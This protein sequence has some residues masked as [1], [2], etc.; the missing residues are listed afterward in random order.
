MAHVELAAPDLP[1]R[2][3][4]VPF[5][6]GAAGVRPWLVLVVGLPG[7]VE[8]LDGGR[9]RLTGAELFAQH[10]LTLAAPLGP[11]PRRRRPAV[12]PGRLAT[13]ADDGAG[14]HRRARPRLA[15]H[16]RGRRLDS[17][18]RLVAV[19][20]RFG[21]P[22]AASTPGRSAPSPIR[23]T[24]PRSPSASTR[25]PRRRRRELRAR[26]FGRAAVGVEPF[27][28]EPLA[29]GG[30]LTVVPQPGDPPLFDDLPG[31]RRRGRRVARRQR[32][33]GRPVGAD[34]AALRRA[35]ASRPRRRRAVAVATAGR[36]R[37]A[38][39]LAARAARRSS[40]PWCRRPRRLGGDRVAG[41]DQRR[42]HT[43]GRR[44]GRRRATHPSPGA[45]VSVRR[46]ACGCG[47]CRPSRW[48]DWR[49]CRR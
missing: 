47:G 34:D 26:R 5:A 33:A 38:R 44:G 27:A 35:V 41:P 39:R 12:R 17:A 22:A 18:R 29:A 6:A 9:V 3:S 43:A 23:A 40:S 30:A 10:P 25:S 13:V 7:E 19:A 2:Y 21:G 4:P 45:S 36:R 20:V 24:S 15:G 42:R 48:P 11:C 31:A 8:L 14:L 37:P 49:R 1:W 46:A 16:R 32:R 28:D